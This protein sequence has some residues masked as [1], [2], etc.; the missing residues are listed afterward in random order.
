MRD[1][2]SDDD[3]G[4]FLGMWAGAMALVFVFLWLVVTLTK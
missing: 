3:L 1:D 4:K 2:D